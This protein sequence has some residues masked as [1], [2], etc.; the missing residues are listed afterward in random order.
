MSQIPA[1]KAAEMFAQI[2]GWPYA[3][4]GTNDQRGIDCSGAWVRVYAAYNESL[5]HGSNTIYRKRCKQTGAITGASDLLLGMAVFKRRFDQQEPAQ[6]RGDGLGNFY[7]MGCVT[8]IKPLRIT[9]ATIPVA[10]V[11][12]T[13]SNWTHWGT[14]DRVVYSTSPTPSAEVDYRAQVAT[15]SGPLNL[16]DA[17][18]TSARILTAI[19]KGATVEVLKEPNQWVPVRYN[20]QSGYASLQYLKRI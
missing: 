9:H 7:H 6:Y 18:N 4:P 20:G 10:K 1:E 3:S 12:T 11:D 2:V 19:P 15:Q 14:M 17:P 16:R 13:L 8:S 5:Y